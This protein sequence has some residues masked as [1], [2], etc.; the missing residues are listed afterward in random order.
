MPL[1]WERRCRLLYTAKAHFPRA[2]TRS[3]EVQGK[4]YCYAVVSQCFFS[5]IEGPAD[6]SKRA[7][8]GR[9]PYAPSRTLAVSD[10]SVCDL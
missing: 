1:R 7:S 5:T 3:Y 4:R 6:K 9:P 10:P 2:L 8:L